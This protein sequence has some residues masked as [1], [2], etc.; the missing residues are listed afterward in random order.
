MKKSK[1]KL[2]HSRKKKRRRYK[3]FTHFEKNKNHFI[4]LNYFTISNHFANSSQF[5]ILNHFAI[6]N[7]FVILNYFTNFRKN[8]F[9][10][11]RIAFINYYDKIFLI[12]LD[13]IIIKNFV[14]FCQIYKQYTI[15]QFSR[16][17]NNIIFALY[18]KIRKYHEKNESSYQYIFFVFEF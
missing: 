3:K 11:C 9:R 14:L 15:I 5:V 12:N 4:I 8:L 17:Y 18:L 6:S 13:F 7:Q 2:M 10:I 1:T 16:I